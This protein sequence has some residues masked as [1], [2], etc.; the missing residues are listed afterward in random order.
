MTKFKI[1]PQPDTEIFINK[2]NSISITQEEN[3][4]SNIIIINYQ[5]INFF[6]KALKLLKK[7]LENNNA[8]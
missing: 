5:S 6:I 1:L 3:E 8:K 4:D 7:E 2:I